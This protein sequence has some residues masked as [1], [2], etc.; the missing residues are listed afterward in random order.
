MWCWYLHSIA[1]LASAGWFFGLFL[2][3]QQELC[4]P[5][6]WTT[7]REYLQE[8]RSRGT[9]DTLAVPLIASLIEKFRKLM[10]QTDTVNKCRCLLNI[11][12]LKNAQWIIT[13]LLNG[14]FLLGSKV[15]N[16]SYFPW[17]CYSCSL[18]L[19]ENGE[20]A[21]FSVNRKCCYKE[22]GKHLLCMCDQTH[23][24]QIR[25]PRGQ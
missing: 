19:H 23:S 9:R 11:I 15:A 25:S 8:I 12:S 16:S 6:H 24:Q 21:N 22:P 3:E 18:L 4:L 7:N 20:I 13:L 14:I 10:A 5:A 17:S 1:Q 2:Q